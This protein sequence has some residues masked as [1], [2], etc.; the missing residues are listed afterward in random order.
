MYNFIICEDNPNAGSIIKGFISDYSAL[1]KLDFRIHLFQNHFERV[2]EFAQANAGHTN[3]YFLDIILNQDNLS[4]LT[5]ARQIRRKDMM[6]YLI[7]ISAHP[8]FSM[9]ILQYKVRALDYLYKLDE[10]F[11]RRICDCIHVILDETNRMMDADPSRQITLKK[12]NSLFSVKLSDILYIETRPGSRL[13]HCTLKDGT[14][15]EFHDTLKNVMK[16]LDNRFFHCHRSYIVNVREIRKLE[17][18]KQYYC[19]TMNDGKVCD[20]SKPNWKELI[21]RVRA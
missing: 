7:F 17:N 20:V 21:S 14:E 1:K 18:E 11:Q 16:S 19:A 2:L 13:I 5:L 6:A 4:G 8:E 9:K 10:N 15:L 3:V 12:A